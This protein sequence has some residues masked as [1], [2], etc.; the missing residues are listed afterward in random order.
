VTLIYAHR[1]LHQVE[2]ENTL[3]SFAAA[4]ELGVDGVELEV[5]RSLDGYLVVNHDPVV[6][7]REIASTPRSRLPGH[8]PTL[9]ESM[10]ALAEVR[11]NVELKVRTR[12][13]GRPD[14]PGA[15]ARQVLDTLDEGGW[16]NKTLI[17]SFSFDECLSSLMHNEQVPVGWAVE[18][19]ELRDALARAHSQGLQAVHPYFTT[20]SE[21]NMVLAGELGL[22]V[23]VWTV[24]EAPD[25]ERAIA[26]GVGIVITDEPELAMQIRDGLV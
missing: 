24:N 15:L 12:A 16:S 1:G 10:I 5:Q 6:M 17:S 3:E 11:V 7:G 23:N 25:I 21:P 14:P 9:E 13:Q 22:D 26:L 2:R 4:A 18:G 8:I 19:S 20:L